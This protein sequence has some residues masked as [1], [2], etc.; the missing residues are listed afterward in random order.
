MDDLGFHSNI[1]STF[2]IAMKGTKIA[3]YVYHSF[4]SLLDN[5]GIENYKGF[6][7]LNQLVNKEAFM[8]YCENSTSSPTAKERYHNYFKSIAFKTES[9]ML[10]EIGALST[11]DITHPHV[12]D[13]LNELHREDIHEMFMFASK[14]SADS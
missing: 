2:I 10:T 7:T 1:Y 6:I 8:S 11:R 12:L 5:Y 9:S 14:Y 3:F 13:L 4:S